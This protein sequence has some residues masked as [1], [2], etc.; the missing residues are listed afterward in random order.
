MATALRIVLR[1]LDGVNAAVRHGLGVLLA[2]ISV[3][4]F[5]QVVVRFLLTNLGLNVAAPWT[6]ELARY[7]LVWMIF[8]GA[9]L[10]CR[11]MQLIALE[12]VL[13]RLPRAL[14]V[15]ARLVALALCLAL[16]ALMIR[17][18]AQF[19]EVIGRTETS[20]VLQIPKTWVYWA[21]PVG[22]ALMAANTLAFVLETLLEGG[23]LRRSGSLGATE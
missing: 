15:A 11:R 20:P 21:M 4:V 8:L 18:G 6:E 19:V 3:V 5:V 7:L 23:D 13:S 16:F 10:G 12:A 2:L 22:A 1:G 14:G 9:G 17:F